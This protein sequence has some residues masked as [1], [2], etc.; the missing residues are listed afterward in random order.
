MELID[1]IQ[2]QLESTYGIKTGEKASDY[3]INKQELL[4][5]IEPAQVIHTPKELFLV[6]PQPQ[7]E[8]LEIALFLDPDLRENLQKNNPLET[9]SKKNIA[10]FCTMIEG[11]SHFVY[12]VHKSCL[13]CDVTQLEME[14]QAEIDKFVFL[15]LVIQKDQNQIYNILD[16][17]FENYELHEDLTP[18]QIERYHTASNL[19]HR[20]CHEL[21]KTMRLN[22]PIEVL[23]KIRQ[24]YPL[25][26]EQKIRQILQ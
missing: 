18:T 16:L 21:S 8:T 3:L 11:I 13:Q 22:N 24:F 25:S 15:S 17:L 23:K 26:Q 9:L 6:N 10:D 1:Q 7:N 5:L 14:L 20:Y 19:A 12:Y 2:L 4:A